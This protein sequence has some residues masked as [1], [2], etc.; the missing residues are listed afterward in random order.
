MTNF[1]INVQEEQLSIAQSKQDGASLALDDLNSMSYGLKVRQSKL[2]RKL[3]HL[4][5][6]KNVK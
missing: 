3:C 5:L 2:N 1:I 6:D 4:H